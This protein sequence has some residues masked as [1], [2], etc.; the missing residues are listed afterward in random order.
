VWVNSG[1]D[2][3]TRDELRAADGMDVTSSVWDGQT[4]RLFGARNEVVNFNVVLEA[5]AGAAGVSVSFDSLTGP[6]GA[7]ISSRPAEGEG[8]FDFVDRNIELFF[9]RYL[10]DKGLS[11]VPYDT[12]DEHRV[13]AKLR[14]PWTGER[15]GSGTWADRRNH[16]RYDP[17]I[18]V[19]LELVSTFPIAASSNQSIWSDIHI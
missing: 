7:M 4:I 18:A 6:N 17:E 1:D 2:K 14:R 5:R 3:V 19:P 12:Y 15:Y 13:P 10:P 11:L 9:V 8:V 16:D